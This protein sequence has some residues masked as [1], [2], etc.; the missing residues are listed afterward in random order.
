MSGAI[1]SKET[2]LRTKNSPL[3]LLNGFFLWVWFLFLCLFYV[4]LFL[5][6]ILLRFFSRRRPP[7]LLL[8]GHHWILGTVLPLGWSVQWEGREHIGEGPYVIVSNHT[9]FMDV[10]T[11]MGLELPLVSVAK[12]SLRR[13]PILGWAMSLSGVVFLRSGAPDQAGA[14]IDSCTEV[15]EDGLSVLIFPE[16]TRSRDRTL[17]R[18]RGGAFRL[19][20]HTNTPILPVI[21]VGTDA[22][23]APGRFIPD[24][25]RPRIRVRVLPPIPAQPDPSALRQEAREAMKEGLRSVLEASNF[26]GLVA[27]AA[28]RYRQIGHWAA[29]FAS[30]KMS[31]DPVYRAV[32]EQLPAEGVLLDVGCGEGYLLALAAAARPELALVGIDHDAGRLLKAQVALAGLIPSPQ[33]TAQDA[34]EGLPAADVVT[35]LDVLHYLPLPQQDALIAAMARSL[36]PGGVLLVREGERGD[37]LGSAILELTERVSVALGR[38]QGDGVFFRPSQSICDAMAASGMSV[39]THPCRQGTPFANTLFIARKVV[40]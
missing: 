12:Q 3:I 32:I 16:G 38:H 37:G 13:V 21:I 19:S 17:G 1:A 34:R 36:K 18:L 25:I 31:Q 10:P 7:W 20:S 23:L 15:L 28:E 27:E 24:Q 26:T 11:L 33:L 22:L 29:G 9:S 35:C 8:R 2:S 39:V 30:G 4:P 40:P 5:L 6:Q 14:F